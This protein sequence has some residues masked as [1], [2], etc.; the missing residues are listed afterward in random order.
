[1]DAVKGN[2]A[3]GMNKFVVA[4]EKG[5]SLLCKLMTSRSRSNNSLS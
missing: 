2:T 1:M 5:V 3:A 4:S